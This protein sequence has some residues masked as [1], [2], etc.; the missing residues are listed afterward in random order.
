MRN[1]GCI[2]ADFF[3]RYWGSLGLRNLELGLLFRT[4]AGALEISCATLSVASV[5]LG[6]VICMCV[7]LW[8]WMKK[9]CKKIGS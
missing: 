1:T 4:R 8:I 2:L 6:L 5:L 7:R 9:L 3:M